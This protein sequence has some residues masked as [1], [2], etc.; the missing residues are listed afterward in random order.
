[1]IHQLKT[2]AEYFEAIAKGLKP[3][4]VRNNDRNFYVGDFLA[5]NELATAEQFGETGRCM[6]VEV[7]YILKDPAFCKD[8]QVIMGIR[9]CYIARQ[10]DRD[11]FTD[12]NYYSV[13]VYDGNK[14]K[15]EAPHE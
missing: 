10:H 4:E 9:P 12:R 7:T 3:F 14:E 5:L 1:M 15:E 8:G 6:L 13:P 2:K 11:I